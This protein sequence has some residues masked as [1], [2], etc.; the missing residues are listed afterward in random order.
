MVGSRSA[1]LARALANAAKK[2]RATMEIAAP[3]GSRSVTVRVSR[4]PPGTAPAEVALVITESGPASQ[5]GRGENAG[6]LLRHAAVVR[7]LL[8][9]GAVAADGT[10]TAAPELTLDPEWKRANLRA[11]AL[12]QETDSRR[13]VGAAATAL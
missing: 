5:V 6:R 2:P 1:D 7:R 13:V 12:V 9:L 4:L 8:R 11:V 10:F 3:A